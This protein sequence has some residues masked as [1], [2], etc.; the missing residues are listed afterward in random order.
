MGASLGGLMA[1]YTALRVP[2]VFHKILSQSGSFSVPEYE[3]VVMDMVRYAPT[4]DIDIWMDV[5]RFEWLLEG[6]RKM[7]ALL[8]ERNYRVKY[9][10]FPGAHNYTSWRNDLWR[11][12]EELYRNNEYRGNMER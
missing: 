5:G 10:E 4:A 11:G 1:L 9:R 8:R 2:Q 6:N 7:C 3:F 12:L